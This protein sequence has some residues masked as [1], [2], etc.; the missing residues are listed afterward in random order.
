MKVMGR[1]TKS[2]I[3]AAAAQIIAAKG[4]EA[5]SLR[6]IAESVGIKKA[7]LY[8]H[9]S[10]KDELVD[11]L[12]RPLLDDLTE[13][14]DRIDTTP[15]SMAAAEEVL[16]HFI[17]ALINHRFVGIWL[18]RDATALKASEHS[19]KELAGLIARLHVWLAGPEPTI[20]DR[21]RAVAATEIVGAVLS[22]M[23]SVADAPPDVLRRTLLESSMAVLPQPGKGPVNRSE[24]P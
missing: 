16:G 21:I 12:L 18:S 24:T 1:D 5:T 7:S 17:E 13:T 11:A 19:I 9:F 8:Y 23:V 4:Y 3:C 2:E 10:S 20:E 15:R 6:E 22:S 14:I